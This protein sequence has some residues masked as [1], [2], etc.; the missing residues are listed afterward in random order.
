VF[1]APDVRGTTGRVGKQATTDRSNIR[2][3]VRSSG[4]SRGIG[5]GGSGGCAGGRAFRGT[6]TNGAGKPPHP[7]NIG[8]LSENSSADGP[9]ACSFGLVFVRFQ[10]PWPK[11][12]AIFE[13]SCFCALACVRCV[14]RLLV[15]SRLWYRAN[16]APSK[17]GTEQLQHRDCFSEWICSNALGGMAHLS[18]VFDA[19]LRVSFEPYREVCRH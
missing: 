17:S 2:A 18:P 5:C 3:S 15:K 7:Y 12:C 6:A 13:T 9:A 19:G 8:R 16:L 4:R 14:V 1:D 10:S 11:R